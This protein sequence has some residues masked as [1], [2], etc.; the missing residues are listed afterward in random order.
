MTSLKGLPHQAPIAPLIGRVFFQ[1]RADSGEAW[2]GQFSWVPWTNQIY[3]DNKE[4]SLDDV[5]ADPVIH[6]LM[7]CDGVQMPSL[8]R[9]ISETQGRIR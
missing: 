1:D 3:R 4:P 5:L 9:L 8:L 6:R 2:S 7:E